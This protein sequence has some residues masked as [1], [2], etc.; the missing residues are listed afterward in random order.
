MLIHIRE[1]ET[2]ATHRKSLGSYSRSGLGW[3]W[4][5]GHWNKKHLLTP[6]VLP[7]SCC[8]YFQKQLQ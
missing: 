3:N 1:E 5:Q 4:Q 2:A 8:C 6:F 7:N